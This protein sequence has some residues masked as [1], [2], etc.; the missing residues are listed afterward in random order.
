MGIVKRKR[1][2]LKKRYLYQIDSP[3]LD[4]FHYLDVRLGFYEIDLPMELAVEKAEAKIP[5][6]YEDFVLELLA[7]V[8]KAEPQK[9]LK[10]ELDGVLVRKGRPIAVLE[11]KYGKASREDI[12]KFLRKTES[13]KC[14]KIVVAEEAEPIEGVEVL[15]PQRILNMVKNAMR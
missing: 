5:L 4:L 3:L 8:L 14:D 6:Y 12:R 9:S 11:V 13:F 2:Y 15:T 1:V 7:Q 10:P